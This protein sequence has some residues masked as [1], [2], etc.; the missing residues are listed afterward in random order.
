[1]GIC[2]KPFVATGGEMVGNRASSLR[3]ISALYVDIPSELCVHP[4]S[5][6][7]VGRSGVLIPAGTRDIFLQNVQ[8]GTG[9]HPVFCSVDTAI[10]SRV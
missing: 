9:A 1:M 7:R 5:R 3:S 6:S 10:L 4:G 2:L 8:T